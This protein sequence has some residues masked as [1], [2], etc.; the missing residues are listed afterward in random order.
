MS[1]LL[2]CELYME[3]VFKKWEIH[4]KIPAIVS[5]NAANVVA[6]IRESNRK[7]IPCFAHT[8]NLVVHSGM[9][10]I[11]L[12]FLKEIVTYFRRSTVAPNALKKPRREADAETEAKTRLCD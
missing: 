1:A 10:H 3:A 9:D 5:D 6:A 2:S 8:L 11:S 4:Y 12:V 7:L